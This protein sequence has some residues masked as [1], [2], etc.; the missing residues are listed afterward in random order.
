MRL[1]SDV[2]RVWTLLKILFSITGISSAYNGK[3][4]S[5]RHISLQATSSHSYFGH[6]QNMAASGSCLSL[7]QVFQETRM[8]T[9]RVFMTLAAEVRQYYVCYVLFVTSKS[10]ESIQIHGKGTI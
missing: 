4:G 2:D 5:T 1:S 7:E 9:M 10:Q 3:T 8:E 6:P